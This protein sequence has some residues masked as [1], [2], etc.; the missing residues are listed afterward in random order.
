M[1]LRP[2]ETELV[3]KSVMVDGL[4]RR[5]ETCNRIEWLTTNH[6][7]QVAVSKQSGVETLFKNPDDGRY[8]ERTYPLSEMHGSGP[9]RLSTLSFEQARQNTNSTD[10][11][12]TSKTC[13]A[14]SKF[15]VP[16]LKTGTSNEHL[17]GFSLRSL[18][19][20]FAAILKLR[21]LCRLV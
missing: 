15:I 2:S 14:V 6:L 1:K 12:P 3:G 11:A 13:P 9:P 16:D 7:E 21:P 18:H 19:C 5:D 20:S 4:V 10:P 8:W 17:P